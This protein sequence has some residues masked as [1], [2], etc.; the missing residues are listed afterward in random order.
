MERF[1]INLL[2]TSTRRIKPAKFR[3]FLSHIVNPTTVPKRLELHGMQFQF[4]SI[5]ISTFRPRS[6]C[7]ICMDIKCFVAVIV[8]QLFNKRWNKIVC[9]FCSS[10]SEDTWRVHVF[11]Q[12]M[13]SNPRHL[14]HPCQLVFVI[15]LML[16]K[17]DCKIKRIIHF[18]NGFRLNHR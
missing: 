1:I 15:G 13:D 18:P 4:R 16:V 14:I 7:D 2:V 5:R 6:F 3:I 17:D 8:N 11:S 10:L 9:D 12:T